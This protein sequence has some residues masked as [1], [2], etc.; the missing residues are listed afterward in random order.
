[1]RAGRNGG[2][3]LYAFSSVA[4]FLQ[5]YAWQVLRQFYRLACANDA[6]AAAAAKRFAKALLPSMVSQGNDAGRAE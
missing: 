3:G 4:G 1:L 2:A 5:S 6:R